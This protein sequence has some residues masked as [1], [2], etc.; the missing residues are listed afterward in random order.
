MINEFF[1]NRNK[2]KLS[3]IFVWINFTN[4]L[5]FIFISLSTYSL[6]TV[7]I[8]IG[9][10]TAH[11]SIRLSRFIYE[12]NLK[13]NNKNEENEEKDFFEDLFD[14]L[15]ITEITEICDDTNSDKEMPFTKRDVEEKES[16]KDINSDENKQD[17]DISK[18]EN[19][20]F[21]N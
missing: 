3:F 10:V 21:T 1:E 2:I 15:K 9:L 5:M 11:Y 7:D 18:L 17:T 19:S 8:L 4:L 12:Y 14:F 16:S 20:I 6:Y 13:E